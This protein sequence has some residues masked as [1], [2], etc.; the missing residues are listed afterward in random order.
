ML[1][2]LQQKKQ[3]HL[4]KLI[5]IDN[6]GLMEADDWVAIGQ[7]L[8]TERGIQ[9]GQ[10]EYDR[11]QQAVQGIWK[12]LSPFIGAK[13]ADKATPEEWSKF[14]EEKVISVDDATYAGYVN[15]VVKGIFT[16]L[17]VN[18]NGAIDAWEYILFMKCMGVK[19]G[20]AHDAFTVL[21]NNGN[22]VLDEEELIK[23][24]E[25][26]F[27]SDDWHSKGNSLFGPL[28]EFYHF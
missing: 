7:R 22:G 3:T 4:F 26:F 6:N 25:E 5:D 15:K 10:Q 24:V 2:A 16:I 23:G 8:T 20:P 17:D 21:D 14:I 19:D 28:P 1:T 18:R 9:K 27:K 11:I 13:Q 12:D